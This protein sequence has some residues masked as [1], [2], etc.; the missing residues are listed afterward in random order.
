[1][2]LIID[3]FLHLLLDSLHHRF[4]AQDILLHPESFLVVGLQR[5]PEKLLIMRFFI[6][7]IT[8]SAGIHSALKLEHFSRVD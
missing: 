4:V 1:M 6:I 5:P 2:D 3:I 8:H 7:S